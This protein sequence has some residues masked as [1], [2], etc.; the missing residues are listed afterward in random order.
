M[1]YALLFAAFTATTGAFAQ[2]LEDAD[3]QP[4]GWRLSAGAGLVHGPKYPGAD[5]Y[6]SRALPIIGATYGPFFFGGD[7]GAGGIPGVGVSLVRDSAWRV[8]V[9]LAPGLGRARRESDHPDLAG[10]GDIERATRATFSAAYAWR[11]WLS[12]TLRAATDIEGKNQG[13][14]VGF[15]IT[16][17]WRG[18]ERVFMTAGP[19]VVWADEDYAMTFFGVTPEQAARSTLPAYQAGSGWNAVRFGVGAG[20]RIDARW[21]LGSRVSISRIVGDAADSPITRDRTPYGAALFAT[22]RF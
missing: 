12:A 13:T 14:L 9:G 1:R 18:T 21:T 7:P 4:A 19:G 16:A 6:R 11:R 17:R 2:P 10:M 3:D 15:D 5:T 8:G 22:Y 20:Y